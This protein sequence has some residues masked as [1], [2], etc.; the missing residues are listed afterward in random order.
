MM[1]QH[2]ETGQR[3]SRHSD[4][5]PEILPF[6]PLIELEH[7]L[8]VAASVTQDANHVWADLWGEFK[9]LATPGGM[10]RPEAKDGFIPS[11]GWPEFLEKLWLLKHYLDSV[12]RICTKQH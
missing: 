6:T 7:L 11:C 5:V 1:P 8:K 4:A 2:K 12:Q 10:I 9:P 3:Q